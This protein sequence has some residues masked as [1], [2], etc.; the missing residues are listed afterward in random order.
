MK[1]RLTSPSDRPMARNPA[2]SASRPSL[3]PMPASNSARPP[4]ASSMTYTLAGPPASTNGTGTGTRVTPRSIRSGGVRRRPRARPAPQPPTRRPESVGDLLD[5]LEVP[6]G[7]APAGDDDAGLGELGPRALHLV[8]L[9]ELA[10]RLRRLD[11]ERLHLAG[12]RALLRGG[13]LRRP[14]RDDANRGRDLHR[15]AGV[16]RPHR[17]LEEDLP[18]FPRDGE[19]VRGDGRPELHRHARSDVLAVRGRRHDH[20]ARPRRLGRRRDRRRMRLRERVF[21]GRSVDR[22]HGDAVGNELLGGGADPATDQH[23]LDLRSAPFCHLLGRGE[24]GERRLLEMSVDLLP[25]HQD[26]RHQITFA[27]ACSFCT[28]VATSGTLIPATLAGG[29]STLSTFT[30]AVTS[31][32]SACAV[33]SWMG[34]FF[35]FMMLGSEA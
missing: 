14:H 32:E 22:V 29:G 11:G 3:V 27:S 24:R 20:V 15:G 8:E 25:N 28:R 18:A 30:L 12:A 9:E 26:R 34:F 7:P 1:M 10:L 23:A 17:A 2:S 33:S 19:D 31:T 35:A 6:L 4:S 21:E 5:G 13:E 16:S